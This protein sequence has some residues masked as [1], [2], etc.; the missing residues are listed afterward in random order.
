VSARITVRTRLDPE[1]RLV[2]VAVTD[3]GPGIAAEVRE[4][5][6][7]PYFTTKARGTGLGLAICQ[8]IVSDHGGT[9]DV[10]SEAGAGATF[11]VA[12]PLERAAA[13]AAGVATP[14]TSGRG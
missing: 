8:R 6:F 3:N 10:R 5:L 12:L 9:I 14:P 2:E 1:G 7:L 13:T 4:K 11:T